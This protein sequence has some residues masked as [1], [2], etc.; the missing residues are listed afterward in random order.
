MASIQTLPE[1]LLLLILG[2]VASIS[3]E[4]AGSMKKSC[5]YFQLI[6]EHDFVYKCSS[7]EKFALPSIEWI[8]EEKPFWHVLDNDCDDYDQNGCVKR[9]WDYELMGDVQ[10]CRLK[11][12]NKER[13]II[14]LKRCRDS[15][16]SIILY[17]EGMIQY[18]RKSSNSFLE[19]IVIEKLKSSANNGH[20]EAKYVY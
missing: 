16:N 7:L 11:E 3:I 17:R 9:R 8:S 18:F 6:A 1:D 2:K 4:D 12:Y 20:N 19:N 14:F 10:F 5:K 13:Q 15:A